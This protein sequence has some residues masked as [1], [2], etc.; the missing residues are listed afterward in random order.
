MRGKLRLWTSF[1]FHSHL[2]DKRSVV[3]L[4]VYYSLCKMHQWDHVM[5]YQREFHI[6]VNIF[7]SRVSFSLSLNLQ[8]RIK[9]NLVPL[10]K[11]AGNILFIDM[12]A[13]CL[14]GFS[15]AIPSVC[16]EIHMGQWTSLLSPYPSKTPPLVTLRLESNLFVFLMG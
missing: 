16:S 15:V 9:I 6:H 14:V 11:H 8:N 13:S 4:A 3:C 2:S 1:V 10:R 12:D 7:Q 5:Y